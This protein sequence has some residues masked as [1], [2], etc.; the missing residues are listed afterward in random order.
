MYFGAVL[1]R[2]ILLVTAISALV[3]C[4][5]EPEPGSISIPESNSSPTSKQ[6]EVESS[7]TSTSIPATSASE[8]RYC[9]DVSGN[10]ISLYFDGESCIFDSPVEIK[11]GTV[12]LI[13]INESEGLAAVNLMRHNEDKTIQDMID[14]FEEEEPSTKHAPGWVHSLGPWYSTPSGERDVWEGVL[15]PGIHTIV[16]GQLSPFG[17]WYGGGF[18]ATE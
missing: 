9:E 2:I 16:C 12:T 18:E 17:V 4:Q 3:A 15:E 13:F 8:S 1:F 5:E 10:C 11:T 7:P 6:V 14:I